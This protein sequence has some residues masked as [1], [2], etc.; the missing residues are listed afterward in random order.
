MKFEEPDHQKKKLCCEWIVKRRNYAATLNNRGSHI[1]QEV[2]F[3]LFLFF[4][5]FQNLT[6]QHNRFDLWSENVVATL[7]IKIFEFFGK[8]ATMIHFNPL[9][10]LSK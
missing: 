1:R 7:E 9:Q 2:I 5:T 6:G 10:F 4:N 8:D 3:D